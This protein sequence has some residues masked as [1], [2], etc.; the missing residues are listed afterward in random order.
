MTSFPAARALVLAAAHPLGTE[1]VPYRYALG[2]VLAA[3]LVAP[4][5]VPHFD[6]SQVDG[7][8]VRAADGNYRRLIG[9]SAAGGP[10]PPPVGPGEAVRIFT[11]APIP[12]GADAVAMQEDAQLEPIS[13]PTG[14]E[15][16]RREGQLYLDPSPSI[17]ENIRRKGEEIAAGTRFD[18]RGQVATPPLIGLAASFGVA[19]PEVYRRPFVAVIATGNELVSPGLPLGPGQVY[20]SNLAA[21]ETAI[22]A[23]GGVPNTRL[24][25]DDAAGKPAALTDLAESPALHVIIPL[26]GVSVGDHDLVRP[27]LARLGVE[28]R[29][30]RVSMKPGKPFY[31][32]I[33]GEKRVY[34][35]PGNPVSALVTFHL[36]VRPALRA[37][38]GLSD[39]EEETTAHLGAPIRRKD[40]RYEFV[41]ATLE[42]GVATP[43]SM[44]GSHMQTGLAFADALIHV[45][46]G[47]ASLE[48]GDEVTVTPL[49]WTL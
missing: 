5:D 45:P 6:N 25:D 7:Y 29:L 40:L 36:L 33:A 17:G 27:T 9:E 1:S 48:P 35:L 30:W 39:A 3:P 37:M 44:Q 20:A 19:E 13:S 21:L 11:G 43:V 12:D 22:R 23:V 42:G 32:G 24:V 38:L 10:P 18:V 14:E 8:A 41:R 34:G 28:E 46:D 26:G 2:R 16:G 31:F 15:M 4:F 47:V 49:R